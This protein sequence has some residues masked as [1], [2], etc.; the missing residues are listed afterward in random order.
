MWTN[1]SLSWL[2]ASCLLPALP[3]LRHPLYSVPRCCKSSGQPRLLSPSK[4]TCP[5]WWGF[6]PCTDDP[7]SILLSVF[8][9]FA[10]HSNTQWIIYTW[11]SHGPHSACWE[12]NVPHT[13]FT[14]LSLQIGSLTASS[15]QEMEPL[16]SA[17]HSRTPTYIILRFVVKCHLLREALEPLRL[18]YVL[19]HSFKAPCIFLSKYSSAV[20]IYVS[21]WCCC[22]S[23]TGLEASGGQECTWAQGV[24]SATCTVRI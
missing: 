17:P 20:I 11:L 1:L 12:F 2:P 19:L 22:I 8:P 24:S 4:V 23:A 21:V 3:L 7:K 18:P 5:G 14:I 9:T 10:A 15:S 16:S 6:L 13:E